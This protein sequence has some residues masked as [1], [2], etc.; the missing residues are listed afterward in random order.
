LARSVTGFDV[1]HHV[2]LRRSGALA[3]FFACFDCRFVSLDLSHDEFFF[4][5]S[6]AARQL[7]KLVGAEQQR[8][9]DK[10]A[11]DDR[12]VDDREDRVNH[13]AY[14]SPYLLGKQR[15]CEFRQLI[16]RRGGGDGL[17][18]DDC[19][20]YEASDLAIRGLDAAF[21]RNALYDSGD[22]VG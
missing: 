19:T 12:C 8:A 20:L 17:Q 13:G 18:S 5:L 2:G 3:S 7:W 4:R 21:V 22:A 15:A 14:G 6:G 1:R 16:L 11:D 10:N 9:N